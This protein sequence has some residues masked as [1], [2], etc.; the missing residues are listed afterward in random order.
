MNTLGTKSNTDMNIGVRHWTASGNPRVTTGWKSW[1][2]EESI[3]ARICSQS[4]RLALIDIDQQAI[5]DRQE[6]L[7]IARQRAAVRSLKDNFSLSF[8]DVFLK[9][10]IWRSSVAPLQTCERDLTLEEQLAVQAIGELDVFLGCV[11]RT[12]NVA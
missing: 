7:A 5:L 8:E 1:H 3:L 4:D 10:D 12:E 6:T 11:A 2:A 9:L